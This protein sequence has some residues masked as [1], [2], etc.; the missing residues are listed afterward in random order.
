MNR[1]KRAEAQALDQQRA[2]AFETALERA[3]SEIRL[4]Q[5]QYQ[6]A[7][8]RIGS[9]KLAMEQDINDLR[10][11]LEQKEAENVR[12]R[13]NVELVHDQ[14]APN[15]A[16]Y[17]QVVK[18]SQQKADFL[19]KQVVSLQAALEEASAKGERAEKQR[20]KERRQLEED[21]QSV[22]DNLVRRLEVEVKRNHELVRQLEVAGNR[23]RSM[24]KEI[25]VRQETS[26]ED[27]TGKMD[28][29][30]LKK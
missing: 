8:E 14:S 9:E 29:L 27:L 15:V 1:L 12:A 16:P 30:N 17:E 21:S 18:E 2:L 13:R 28:T 20:L 7:E 4:W 26:V 10:F 3:T 5:S 6:W 22:R 11:Q 24:E 19:L 23:L 25:A